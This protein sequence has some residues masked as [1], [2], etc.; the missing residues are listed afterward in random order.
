M[1]ERGLWAEKSK[2]EGGKWN[3]KLSRLVG[4]GKNTGEKRLNHKGAGMLSA[5]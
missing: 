3:Y 5:K 4:S 1:G 2:D